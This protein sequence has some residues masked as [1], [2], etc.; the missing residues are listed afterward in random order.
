MLL[1]WIFVAIFIKTVS[2]ADLCFIH[3]LIATITAYGD[4]H[5][6]NFKC[7]QKVHSPPW[8]LLIVCG[9]TRFVLP[10]I[11]TISINGSVRTE[12][13]IL[14]GLCCISSLCNIFFWADISSLRRCG[15][16]H[17]H[18][19]RTKKGIN[20]VICDLLTH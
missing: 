15:F 3:V 13:V 9:A 6:F 16:S 20:S 7:L 10:S 18:Y 2:N 14:T 4:C 12:I 11:L 8:I 5:A 1:P 17:V 19:R